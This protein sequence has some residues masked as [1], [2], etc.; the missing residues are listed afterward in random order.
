M[1]LGGPSLRLSRLSV[2]RTVLVKGS[3]FTVAAPG[4][5]HELQ[6]TPNG[7]NA[8]VVTVTNNTISQ[9]R[10]SPRTGK[11][12]LKPASTA[13][14]VLHPEA[15]KIAV[16]GMN[17]YVTSENDG[18]LSQFAIS[19]ATGK[20]T[21]MSPA[22]VPTASGSLGLAITPA[23]ADHIAHEQDGCV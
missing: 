19:P 7:K 23:C 17:A 15:I 18:V 21:P 16:N 22:T 11:L 8:Y 3:T 2:T 9:Y 6:V 14:T 12:S 13:R 5:A 4:H 1:M 20:I 10:I